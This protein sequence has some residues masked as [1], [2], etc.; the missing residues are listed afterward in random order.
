[1]GRVSLGLPV[2][3]TWVMLEKDSNG[4]SNRDPLRRST[5]LMDQSSWERHPCGPRAR[6]EDEARARR[7]PRPGS[8]REDG[9]PADIAS[10]PARPLA[11]LL[12]EG[13]IARPT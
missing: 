8:E 5:P 10:P 4:V 12:P 13:R 6:A 2:A 11:G 9:G 1:M 3:S 7:P